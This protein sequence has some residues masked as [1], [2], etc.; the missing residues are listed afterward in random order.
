[1]RPLTRGEGSVDDLPSPQKTGI[2]MRRPKGMTAEGLARKVQGRALF[3]KLMFLSEMEGLLP[4][5][6]RPSLR[7]H[8][9]PPLRCS[10][11]S[12]RPCSCASLLR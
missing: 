7:F 12:L 4:A 5:E 11:D 1:M 9:V 2:L 10:R 3:S 6:A 8:C